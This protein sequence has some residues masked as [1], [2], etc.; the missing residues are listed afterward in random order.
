MP[1]PTEDQAGVKTSAR[2]YRTGQDLD[3]CQGLWEDQAE[4]SL[5][6][7]SMGGP[8]RSQTSARAYGRTEQEEEGK[9][10]TLESAVVMFPKVE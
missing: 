6:P 1:E 9:E 10:S 7:G 2:A 4:F 5:V 3:Q 8:G